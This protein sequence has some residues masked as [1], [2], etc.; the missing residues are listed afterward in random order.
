MNII[1]EYGREDLAKVYVAQIRGPTT[2]TALSQKHLIEF[3]ESIQPPY[4]REKKWVLIVSSMIGCPIQCQMCDAGGD[5]ADLL[6]ADEILAQINYLVAKRYP[7]GRPTT[8]KFKIQFARMG[9]PSLNPAVLEVLKRL[10]TYYPQEQLH[11]SLST[12][13]PQTP[14]V[15]RFF[16]QLRS[17]KDTYYT[18]GRFQLQFSIHTTD[19][20]ARNR[21]IPVK[22]WSFTEI[23]TYGKKFSHPEHMDK[24]ITLNF[25]PVQGY[26]IDVEK[27]AE[28]FDPAYFLIKLTPV[29]PTVRSHEQHLI[30]AINP[31]NIQSADTLLADFKKHGYDVILSIGELEENKIGSNCGQFVQRALTAFTRPQHS[32]EIERYGFLHH[33]Q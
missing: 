25:A 30:S 33:D 26:Q 6:T 9:E 28:F 3:V 12:V 7:T 13:A 21:L 23:A 20:L 1:A 15:H 22:K 29:N 31:T 14:R 2:H 27:L 17:I 18:E 11:I 8:E 19:E 32:Y 10:P 16:D 24:K 4:P 5:F